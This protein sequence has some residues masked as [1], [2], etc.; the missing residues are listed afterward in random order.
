ML[1]MTQGVLRI[2]QHFQP[3]HSLVAQ[4]RRGH[5]CRCQP[6][7]HPCIVDHECAV[8]IHSFSHHWA[9]GLVS[10]Q[11]PLC[12]RFTKSKGFSVAMEKE[13][14]DKSC[15]DQRKH[16]TANNT[17]ISSEKGAIARCRRD[18][19]I[20]V[21][22]LFAFIC[23]YLHLSTSTYTCGDAWLLT[24]CSMMKPPQRTIS[25]RVL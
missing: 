15:F 9:S 18:R 10:L 1:W 7:I 20:H 14:D 23:I 22:H 13:K 12:R 5:Q 8:V 24:L 2:G 19:M 17:G 3:V 6:P 4:G 16:K 11:H 21:L 25:R